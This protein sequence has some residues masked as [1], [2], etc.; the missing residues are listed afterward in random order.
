MYM[1]V[2]LDPVFASWW[3]AA[4]PGMCGGFRPLGILVSLIPIISGLGVCSSTLSLNAPWDVLIE[5]MLMCHIFRLLSDLG[6][7]GL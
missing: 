7:G 4:Y 1:A 3:C 5:F 2:P 6:T